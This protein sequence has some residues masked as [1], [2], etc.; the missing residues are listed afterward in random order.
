MRSTI[1]GQ[2]VEVNSAAAAAETTMKVTVMEVTE[3]RGIVHWCRTKHRRV[4]LEREPAR[5]R[6][7]SARCLQRYL[8]PS[9][10]ARLGGCVPFD[11]VDRI[12]RLRRL[13][14]RSLGSQ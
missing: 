3:L 12:C 10:V 5:R 9:G 4:N 13:G 11:R 14:R 7:R 1:E 6:R 2:R 8:T